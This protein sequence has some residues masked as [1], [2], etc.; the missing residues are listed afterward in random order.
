[1]YITRNCHFLQP[2]V[3]LAAVVS[4]VSS[5]RTVNAPFQIADSILGRHELKECIIIII[6]IIIIIMVIIIIIII[7][8]IFGNDHNKSKLHPLSH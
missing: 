5:H 1:V 2:S 7:I 6:I 3:T 4:S 8:Q